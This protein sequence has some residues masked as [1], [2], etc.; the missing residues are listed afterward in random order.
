MTPEESRKFLDR[1][2]MHVLQPQFRYDHAHDPGD[3]TLWDNYMTLHTSPPIKKNIVSIDDARLLYRLSCK[4]EPQAILPRNDPPGWL[5][6]H[7]TGAYSTPD[8][9][10]NLK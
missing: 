1:L 3:V 2:E 7:I 8:E 10:I 9:I 5:E 6:E 4:G